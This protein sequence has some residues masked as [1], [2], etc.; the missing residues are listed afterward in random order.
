MKLLGR[1]R[2]TLP[3]ICADCYHGIIKQTR[4]S[5]IFEQSPDMIV[6]IREIAIVDIDRIA[7]II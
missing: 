7:S 3:M 5:E 4:R 6:C 2:E 1:D